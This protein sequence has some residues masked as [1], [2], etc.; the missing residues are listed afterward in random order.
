VAGLVAHH[1]GGAVKETIRSRGD[2]SGLDQ[3][4]PDVPGPQIEERA[5]A[6]PVSPACPATFA[7]FLVRP[8]VGSICESRPLRQEAALHAL[9]YWR[10][11]N[12]LVR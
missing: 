1:T 11:V 8:G 4:A 9:G 7:A 10:N 3:A 6:S 5:R 12:V 2:Q